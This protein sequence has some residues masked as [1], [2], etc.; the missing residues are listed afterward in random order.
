MMT[1]EKMMMN[2]F[3]TLIS[4]LSLGLAEESASP[5]W[6][7]KIVQNHSGIMPILII[8][9]ICRVL[10][11]VIRINDKHHL[12]D[13][14]QPMMMMAMMMMIIIIIIIVIIIIG[15]AV[16]WVIRSN[17]KHKQETTGRQEPTAKTKMM[18]V[19]MIIE[20]TRFDYFP[21]AYERIKQN[22][23][24]TADPNSKTMQTTLWAELKELSW[25]VF[26]LF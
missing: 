19:M 1:M 6:N 10:I 11:W 24:C 16:I 17:D 25:G 7:T 21:M 3:L 12:Q 2:H 18:M 26:K 22:S 13:K 15:C 5:Y 23:I 20:T 14:R 4:D 8:V 9:I